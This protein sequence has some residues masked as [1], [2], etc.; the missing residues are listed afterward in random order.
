[1]SQ[2][3]SKEQYEKA[4][5]KLKFARSRIDE[6]RGR[7]LGLYG[8]R[9][10]FELAIDAL[11]MAYGESNESTA[12]HSIERMVLQDGIEGWSRFWKNQ[13]NRYPG[14]SSVILQSDPKTAP[15][16]DF[17]VAY[18]RDVGPEGDL[19]DMRVVKGEPMPV[20]ESI[21]KGLQ[22]VVD[23][24]GTQ[25]DRQKPKGFLWF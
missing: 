22:V 5:S 11:F 8:V 18:R 25:I 16:L 20:D 6:V 19:L 12:W 1:M 9:K 3:I 15:L 23:A 2:G 21:L 4:N 17:I 7:H 13:E 14:I 24:F 10:T